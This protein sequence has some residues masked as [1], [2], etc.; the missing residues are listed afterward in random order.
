MS[1]LNVVFDVEAA[2]QSESRILFTL[3]DVD[4]WYELVFPYIL[5]NSQRYVHMYVD[6]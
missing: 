1:D 5:T 2:E 3:A 4:E 6:G